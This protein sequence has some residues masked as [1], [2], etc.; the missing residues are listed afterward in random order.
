MQHPDEPRFEFRAFRDDVA[1]LREAMQARASRVE[2]ATSTEVY[3]V[4]RLN[5]D[6]IVKLREGNL[7]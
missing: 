2:Q 6:A 5:I 7:T 1:L 3:L 4:T